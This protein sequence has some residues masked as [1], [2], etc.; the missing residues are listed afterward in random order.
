MDRLQQLGYQ[1]GVFA[2]AKLTSPEFDQTVF[3]NVE[4]LRLHSQGKSAPERDIN[5]T[6]D[7]KTWYENRNK[8]KPLFS[9]LFYDA[10]HAYDF[11]ENYPDQYQPLSKHINY[12]S[13]DNQTDVTPIMNRY[14]TSVRFVDSLAKQVIDILDEVGDLDN[15]L[16]IITG[17]HSQEFNDN[18]LNYWGHNSN[19][20]PAQTHVPFA[21]IGPRVPDGVGADWGDKFTSHE[22]VVPTL[23][24]NYLGATSPASDYSTGINVFSEVIDRPW[25]LLSSYS[26]YGIVTQNSILE[27]GATGQ[28]RY[29]DTTNHPKD[30]NPNF[31]YVQE[32]LE[33]ISRF[34]K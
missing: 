12:L 3:S 1:L 7:W 13:L 18:K 24:E 6:E 31:K 9:F 32:A 17:D 14:K 26:G 25:V 15:T 19:Y 4:N 10:P 20:T 33:Q 29:L 11:P 21:I 8:S 28:S 27:V 23:M 34:R 2:S 30:G 16:I 22:D 5:L